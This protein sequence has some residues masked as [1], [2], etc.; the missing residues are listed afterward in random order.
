MHQTL[1]EGLTPGEDVAEVQALNE[2]GRAGH[3][4]VVTGTAQL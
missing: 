3:D 2:Q 1:Q 4:V